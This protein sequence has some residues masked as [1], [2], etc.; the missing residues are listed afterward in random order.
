VSGLDPETISYRILRH[1]ESYGTWVQDGIALTDASANSMRAA[2]SPEL[3]KDFVGTIEIE[4]ADRVGNVFRSVKAPIGVDVLAPSA[5]VLYPEPGSTVV[6]STFNAKVSLWD[7]GGSGIDASSVRYR[8]GT[9]GDWGP[10][11]DPISSVGSDGYLEHELML[12]EGNY[13]LQYSLMDKAGNHRIAPVLEFSVDLPPED[14]PP[15]AVI[16]S[17][18]NG[19]MID[20]GWPILLSAEGT[21]DDGLGLYDPVKMT[22]TSNVSGYLGSGV[23]VKVYLP[24][25]VHMIT[26][27]ADDGTPGH[28]VSASVVVTVVKVKPSEGSPDETIGSSLDILGAVLILVFCLVVTAGLVTIALKAYGKSRSKEARIEVRPEVTKK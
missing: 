5:E 13:S 14:R 11:T 7:T 6:R 26:L 15:V 19:T 12:S 18:K 16:R 9:E 2:F 25:G 1:N 21:T 8:I 10:W 17:P 20:E 4:A 24:A 22:W 28:N 23:R 27:Q 3:G